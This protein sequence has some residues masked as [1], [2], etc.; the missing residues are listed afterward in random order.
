MLPS[1]NSTFLAMTPADF[2]PG[3][4]LYVEEMLEPGLGP[5]LD[6]TAVPVTREDASRV[7]DVS[8]IGYASL[9]YSKI[10][11]IQTG[12][13]GLGLFTTG[14]GYREGDIVGPYTG[15]WHT[16]TEILATSG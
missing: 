11:V 13:K 9:D 6:N 14:P 7:R 4:A 5:F 1:K 16:E 2:E 10:E 15:K 12:E 8:S 3:G